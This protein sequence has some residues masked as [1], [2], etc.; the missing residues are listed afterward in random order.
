[1]TD[2]VAWQT[3]R[4]I[5]RIAKLG[6]NPRYILDAIADR[7]DASGRA[8]PSER[9]LAESTDMSV[10]GVRD[11]VRELEERGVLKITR[12]GWH[13]SNIYE[14]QLRVLAELPRIGSDQTGTVCRPDDESPADFEPQTGRNRQPDRHS[15]P[16][17]HPREAGSE[18]TTPLPPTGGTDGALDWLTILN[19][20]TGASFKATK[21]NLQHPRQRIREGFTLDQAGAVVK[22]KLREWRGTEFAKFLRPATIYGTKF[23]G[24]LQ[25]S[26]NGHGHDPKR[27]NDAWSEAAR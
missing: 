10:R 18:A 5:F 7:A 24:Y 27:V 22:A 15:L 6:R 11:A 16:P 3:R 17:K 23:D 12:R 26:R 4:L 9:L 21:A 25:A 14:I 2:S 1:M 8:W 19:D 13:Q 20:E